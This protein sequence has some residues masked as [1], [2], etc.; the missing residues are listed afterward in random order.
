M[1]QPGSDLKLAQSLNLS[2]ALRELRASAFEEIRLECRGIAQRSHNQRG[3]QTD[4]TPRSLRA[5]PRV[6]A[7]KLL[8]G[9]PRQPWR[10]L[11]LRNLRRTRRSWKKALRRAPSAGT[12]FPPCT[13]AC[14]PATGLD[15]RG[16]AG[17]EV[18]KL[19][20]RN[21]RRGAGCRCQCMCR[22]MCWCRL[23]RWPL[24]SQ[25][26]ADGC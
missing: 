9:T 8:C 13:S 12:P 10:P 20:D 17:A 23:R 22:C 24:L 1:G 21:I 11:R 14:R 19:T 4:S 15:Q 25:R 18:R 2:A 3:R 7:G 6:A 26:R 16:T 5:V